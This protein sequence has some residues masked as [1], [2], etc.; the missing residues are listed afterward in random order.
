MLVMLML[1]ILSG[2]AISD[3][4]RTDVMV[5]AYSVWVIMIVVIVMMQS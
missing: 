5:S 2:R 4:D 1:L 3:I